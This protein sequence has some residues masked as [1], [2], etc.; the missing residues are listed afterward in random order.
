MKRL[1]LLFVLVMI[2]SL[3]HATTWYVRSDG[4]TYGTT[5]TTCNGSQDLPYVANSGP[6]CA[7]NSIYEILSHQ[8][9]GSAS[10]AGTTRISG[11]DTVFF[12]K[13]SDDLPIGYNRAT[14]QTGCDSSY[15]GECYLSPIPSGSVSNP[16]KIYGY[17]YNNGCSSSTKVRLYGTQS[18]IRMINLKDSSNVDIRCIEITDKSNCGYRVGTPTCSESYPSDVGDYGRDGIY[19]KN[20]SNIRIED[21]DI[22]GMADRGMLFGGFTNV[23]LIGVKINGNYFAGFDGDVGHTGSESSFSGNMIFDRV[24]IK[25]NGCSEV[26][27]RSANFSNSDYSNCTDQNATP[28]GYGDGL[29]TYQTSGNWYFYN[30]D[31]SFNTSDGLD[32]LYGDGT[33][34]VYIDK[35]LFEGNVGNQTKVK[36]KNVS[37]TNNIIIATCKYLSDTGKVYNT[38]SFVDCRANGT[39][40]S[41]LSFSGGTWS[42]YN[43]TMVSGNST[44]GSPAIEWDYNSGCDGTESYYFKNNIAIS[45]NATWVFNYNGMSGAC[46]TAFASRVTQY[47][48]IYNFM[49]SPAGTGNLFTNANLVGAI[50][51]T[52]D[53]NLANVYL[54]SSSPGKG[55]GTSGLSY[56]NSSNDYNNYR[57]NSPVD[58]GAIQ[59]GSI[60]TTHSSSST[61]IVKLSGSLKVN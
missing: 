59:Y 30:V 32:L 55:N 29:G 58:M 4:T 12:S 24:Q 25:F 39:P 43:N 14:P 57:Q 35:S 1:I 26:Y 19:G 7:V 49:D 46:S 41:A 9:D 22:H 5:S 47:N 13:P 38:G 48:N 52:A 36:G 8:K 28:A 31:I 10:T 44:A 54:T 33:N 11:G 60:Y 56:W 27:P 42:V 61:G 20:G 23:T 16:T 37:M 3:S 2:P 51:G 6:N 40:I 50:S 17:G 21:V 53:S 18:V 45:P 15:P 34:N